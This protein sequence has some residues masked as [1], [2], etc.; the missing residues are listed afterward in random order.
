MAAV[1]PLEDDGYFVLSLRR[2]QSQ[3][4]F[5]GSAANYTSTKLGT[6]EPNSKSSDESDPSSAPASPRTTHVESSY[7]SYESTPASYLPIA[8]GYDHAPPLDKSLENHFGLPRYEH[9]KFFSRADYEFEDTITIKEETMIEQVE[10]VPGDISVDQIEPEFTSRPYI[11]VPKEHLADDTAMASKPSSQVDYLSHNWAEEDIW[12]SWRYIVSNRGELSDSA[13]LENASWRTWMKAKN[14]LKTISPESLNWLKDCDV[15]WLYG[16]LQSRANKLYDADTEP[17]SSNMSKTESLVNMVTKKPILK[18]RT[19]SG[20]ML[21]HSISS[22]SLLKQATVSIAVQ[23]NGMQTRRC[24][25]E[26]EL[27]PPS[28]PARHLSIAST[29]TI[30][31]THSSG[32]VSPSAERKHIHFNESVEQCISIDVKGEDDYS[33]ADMEMYYDS[34]DSDGAMMKKVTSKKPG[35]L[36]KAPKK[37]IDGKIIA[38]LR[39]TKLKYREDAEERD[40]AMRHSRSPLKPSASSQET[41]CPARQQNG[42]YFDEEDDNDVDS[43]AASPRN[44]WT[45]PSA[46]GGLQRSSSTGSLQAAATGL[47]RTSSGMLMPQEDADA[48]GGEGIIGRVIDTVNKARDIAHVIWNVGWRA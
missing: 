43:G 31:S 34:S 19:M 23:E 2:M 45:S 27:I 46:E 8:S 47:R 21:Q 6:H 29:S 7:L 17:T 28:L 15:T 33:K 39:S 5:V 20:I 38:K 42:F 35:P 1:L 40:T 10:N 9:A 4:K 16:P 14:N 13:R 22:S 12:T 41:L 24:R 37:G 36:R 30:E 26:D 44:G 18:K 25:I 48:T 32:A 11:P 3:T